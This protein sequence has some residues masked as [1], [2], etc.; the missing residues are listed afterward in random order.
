MFHHIVYIAYIIQEERKLKQG[1]NF[2]KY[3][4]FTFATLCVVDVALKKSVIGRAL[5]VFDFIDRTF[6]KSTRLNCFLCIFQMPR[7]IICSNDDCLPVMPRLRGYETRLYS[8]SP[9]LLLNKNE[10]AIDGCC[11]GLEECVE[12]NLTDLR[13]RANSFYHVMRVK[14]PARNGPAKRKLFGRFKRIDSPF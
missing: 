1:S 2:S 11:A 12:E 9:L 3:S 5:A 4:N 14:K 13:S 8:F 6:T 7:E 10:G